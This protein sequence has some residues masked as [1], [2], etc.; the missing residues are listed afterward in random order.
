MLAASQGI[1][2]QYIQRTEGYFMFQLVWPEVKGVI[3]SEPVHF[4][5]TTLISQE[6][7]SFV[8]LYHVAQAF[9]M[10]RCSQTAAM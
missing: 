7:L 5:M 3:T 10:N 8:L 9:L 1:I 6:Y 4:V 2:I